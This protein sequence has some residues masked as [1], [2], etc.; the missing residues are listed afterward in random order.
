MNPTAQ[1]DQIIALYD[2]TRGRSGS[3]ARDKFI[4][5]LYQIYKEDPE[6]DLVDSNYQLSVQLNQFGA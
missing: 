1:F 4:H 6:F 3:T 2:R 5:G